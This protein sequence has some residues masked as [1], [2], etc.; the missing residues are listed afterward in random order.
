MNPANDKGPPR[1]IAQTAIDIRALAEH[2][3][4]DE[5]R[6]REF[7]LEHEQE[8]SQAVGKSA[9]EI[10]EELGALEGLVPL[11]AEDP[12]LSW[13]EDPNQCTCDF[14]GCPGHHRQ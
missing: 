13:D 5:D 3:N 8:I 4:V 2:F 14:F 12:K 11:E 9:I 10:V 6:M 1:Y 7:C